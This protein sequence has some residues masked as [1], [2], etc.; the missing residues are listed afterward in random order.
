MT[1]NMDILTGLILLVAGIGVVS[2]V[3][4]I[5]RSKKWLISI[6]DRVMYCLIGMHAMKLIYRDEVLASFVFLAT[7]M[8]ITEILS[9][10]KRVRIFR[11]QR[12]SPHH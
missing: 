11:R 3:K 12:T 9:V 8:F 5:T 2:Y 4:P 6:I 10:I 1:Y 7:V